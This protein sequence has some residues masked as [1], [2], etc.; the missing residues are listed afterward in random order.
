MIIFSL[1]I[2]NIINFIINSYI[3]LIY[4][5]YI[6]IYFLKKRKGILLIIISYIT[7]INFLVSI[8]NI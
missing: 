4:I 1:S 5:I 7:L 8:N 6:Y 3:I 2:R